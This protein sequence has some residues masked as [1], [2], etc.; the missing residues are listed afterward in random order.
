MKKIKARY[1]LDDIK[2]LLE[3][4]KGMDKESAFGLF[5]E[6]LKNYSSDELRQCLNNI[7]YIKTK[8]DI[9]NLSFEEVKKEFLD[10]FNKRQE[11]RQ[12]LLKNFYEGFDNN[13]DVNFML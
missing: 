12:E 13:P 9:S 1:L 11:E 4:T 7:F 2:N 8:K 10:Y 6:V 5:S 3:K